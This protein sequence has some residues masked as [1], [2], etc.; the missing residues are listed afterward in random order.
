M[1]LLIGIA[2]TLCLFL[3]GLIVLV[4][5]KLVSPA[6][7]PADDD[8]PQSLSVFRYRPLERLLDDREYR[9]LENHPA[10]SRKMLRRLRTRRIRL[11]REYLRCLSLDYG[12]V[13]QAVKLLMV[14][15]A[16]DRADLARVLVRQRLIFTVRL[17][18]S[19][20]WLTLHLAGVGRVDAT[21]MVAALDNMRAELNSLLNA[22]PAAAR[23]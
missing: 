17:V 18:M 11:F 6:S 2:T 7:L 5:R 23:I 9:R 14:H 15:S 12:R 10:I 20:C 3:T 8:W 16:V 4:C 19:E 1:S 13:C 22:Q 21:K